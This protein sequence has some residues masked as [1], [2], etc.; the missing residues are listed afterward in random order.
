MSSHRCVVPHLRTDRYRPRRRIQLNPVKFAI[1]P[2]LRRF[3]NQAILAAQIGH[4]GLH[5]SGNLRI[6]FIPMK[7]TSIRLRGYLSQRGRPCRYSLRRIK[8][9]C[10]YRSIRF[11]TLIN[12]QL[13]VRS[14]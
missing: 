9:K 4:H 10:V 13:H 1:V 12:C 6:S 14:A 3:E 5:I 2:D 8:S 7:N 11:L